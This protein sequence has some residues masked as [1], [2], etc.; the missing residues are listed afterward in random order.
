MTTTPSPTA[1]RPTA[2]DAVPQERSR[3]V[4]GS[5]SCVFGAYLTLLL[6][7]VTA[8]SGGV[9]KHAAG[10]TSPAS[11]TTNGRR[12]AVGPPPRRRALGSCPAHAPDADVTSLN[13]GVPGLSRQLIPLPTLIKVRVCTY[14]ARGLLDGSVVLKRRAAMDVEVETNHL[15]T[16]FQAGD[17]PHCVEPAISLINFLGSRNQV[18]VY[19][20]SCGV[21]KATNGVLTVRPTVT[22][23]SRLE[24]YITARPKGR[25]HHA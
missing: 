15:E 3:R 2:L 22:W 20:N 24:H 4:R 18:V 6:V 5:R 23:L 11:T 12:R 19:E 8:C 17:V 10:A 21:A 1:R 16:Y 7:A 25:S 14:S 9:G 13:A